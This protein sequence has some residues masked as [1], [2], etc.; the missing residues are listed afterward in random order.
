MSIFYF[1]NGEFCGLNQPTQLPF[2][3]VNPILVRIHGHLH[4]DSFGCHFTPFIG[5][6]WKSSPQPRSRIPDPLH[7]EC[8]PAGVWLEDKERTMLRH[9]SHPHSP[10]II[11]LSYHPPHN[12][13]S[14]RFRLVTGGWS[15]CS[16]S[17][18]FHPQSVPFDIPPLDTVTF[19]LC[20]YHSQTHM[21]TTDR[22]T[23][24]Q[25]HKYTHTHTPLRPP[26]V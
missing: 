2:P 24:G 18:F 12:H 22:Q 13:L 1:C 26:S 6:V 7:W 3:Y 21:Y 17:L 23:D 4:R 16:P 9:S 25:A 10:C 5:S 8:P 19:N 20:H 15:I 14:Q 11:I